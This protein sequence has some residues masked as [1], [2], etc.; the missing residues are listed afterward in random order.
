MCAR[1]AKQV[2]CS[3]AWDSN[4]FGA[5]VGL[6]QGSIPVPTPDGCVNGGCETGLTW[7]NDVRR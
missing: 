5:E 4:S 3:V 2:F 6:H 7:I 1:D